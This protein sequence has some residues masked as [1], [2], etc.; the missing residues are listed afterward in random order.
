[1]GI[2]NVGW[3][4][5]RIALQSSTPIPELKGKFYKSLSPALTKALEMALE[6][7]ATVRVVMELLKD[8]KMV[9]K[10]EVS[11]IRGNK[12]L[13]DGTPIYQREVV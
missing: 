10:Y 13:H 8:G 2:D 4:E 1:M 7:R 5:V 6:Y 9:K 11:I 12:F 3:V